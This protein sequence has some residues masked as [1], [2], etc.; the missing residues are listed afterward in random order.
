MAMV[1]YFPFLFAVSNAISR[2]LLISNAN[3]LAKSKGRRANAN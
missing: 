3:K 2:C 1:H